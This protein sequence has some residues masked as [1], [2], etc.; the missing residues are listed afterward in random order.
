MTR[1]P[2]PSGEGAATCDDGASGG[3]S[4]GNRGGGEGGATHRR[5]GGQWR[6]LRSEAAHF[7]RIDGRGEN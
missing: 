7:C 4:A 6:L 3:G 5:S 1:A 2:A